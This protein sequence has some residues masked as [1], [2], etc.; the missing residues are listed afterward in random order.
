MM[1]ITLN[2][3]DEMAGQLDAL[4]DR[5]P[6]LLYEVMKSKSGRQSN[7][8]VASSAA[9]PA[10][11]EMFAFLA[12]GP[13]PGQIIAHRPS[14]ALRERLAQLLEKNSEAG[15]SEGE[16]AELDGYEQVED[17]LGLLKARAHLM[18]S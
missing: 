6:A 8:A 12:S 4:Q 9:H 1:T 13:S 18:K 17:L 14:A 16:S 5:L 11:Q 3:P 15:L 7:A 2:V 10:Y